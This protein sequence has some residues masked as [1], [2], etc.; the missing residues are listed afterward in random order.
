[1]SLGGG[2]RRF[3]AQILYGAAND[4]LRRKKYQRALRCIIRAIE[5]S[6]EGREDLL[7][8]SCLGRCYMHCSDHERAVHFLSETLAR[9]DADR[10][11][12]SREVLQDEY[13][14]VQEALTYSRAQGGP[15]E[16]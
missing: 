12:W 7:F 13:R 14:R 2:V 16:V 6:P 8:L 11:L 10:A 15:G 9:M 5:V 3:V 1:M 4:A